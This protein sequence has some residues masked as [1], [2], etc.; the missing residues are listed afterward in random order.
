MTACCHHER[1]R[2]TQG[3]EAVTRPIGCEQAGQLNS[4]SSSVKAIP[5]SQPVPRAA[6]SQARIPEYVPGWAFWLAMSRLKSIFPVKRW[7]DGTIWEVGNCPQIL[8]SEVHV[9]KHNE[10]LM[11]EGALAAILPVAFGLLLLSWAL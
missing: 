8:D 4:I 11:I 2:Q 6:P 10:L 3:R 7:K 5:F 1:R 9:F